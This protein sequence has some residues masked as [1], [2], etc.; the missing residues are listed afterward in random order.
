M[1]FKIALMAL[2]YFGA[3]QLVFSTAG[4]SLSGM[5]VSIVIFLSEG[6]ALA[7]VLIYGRWL[8]LGIFIGQLALALNAGLPPAPAIGVSVVNSVEALIAVALFDRFGLDRSLARVRDVT[9]LLLLIALVLQPFSALL[10]NLVLLS[11]GVVTTQQFPVTVFSW[12]FGNMLGQFLLTPL[13]LLLHANSREVR[14]V[15]A[16]AVVAFFLVFNYL[17]LFLWPVERL[18]VMLSL[19]LPPVILLAAYTHT[20]YSLLAT[21]VISLGATFAT[22][23][24]EGAFATGNVVSDIIDLNFYILVHVALALMLGT[25]FAER[26]VAERRLE[27]KNRSLREMVRLREQVE[28]MN[29]HDLKNPLNVIVNAP[30]FIL[31]NEPALSEV[32][33]QMLQACEE[34]GYT[35]LDMVNRSLDIYRIETGNYRLEPE[36]VDLLAVLED[37][38][39]EAPVTP[40]AGSGRSRVAIADRR[41]DRAA[42]LL[43]C[44][45][46]LLC[47]S[48]FSNLVRNALEASSPDGPVTIELAYREPSRECVVTVTNEGSVPEGIRNRFFDKLVTSGK[49]GGVGIGTYSAR[50]CTEVQGGRI[51]ADFSREHHTRVIVHLPCWP[52]RPDRPLPAEAGTAEAPVRGI[53]FAQPL[54]T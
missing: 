41:E 13:L 1:L 20:V 54:R 3:G 40:A 7:G 48:L 32:S 18:S 47:H 15:K 44:G 39:K 16:L 8:A 49:K 28:A 30:R 17:I 31:E 11:S 43:A 2:L 12:W 14:P 21:L 23:Q 9:G 53:G 51:E 38:L 35:M 24:G 26:R 19:T 4:G 36:R 33:R 6:I 22:R 27:E 37:V 46:R 52:C 42:P 45:E 10:G 25:L 29:R 34:S 50:L 5:I